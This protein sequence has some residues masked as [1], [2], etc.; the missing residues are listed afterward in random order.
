VND[1]AIKV[2]PEPTPAAT[3][4][5]VSAKLS[6]AALFESGASPAMIA[7][8]GG[9]LAAAAGYLASLGPHLSHRNT[10]LMWVT[11]AV[12]LVALGLYEAAG[13]AGVRAGRVLAAAVMLWI[14]WLLLASGHPIEFTI[15]WLLAGLAVPM[16]GYELLS[17]STGAAFLRSERLLLLASSVVV[18]ICW[19]YL[20]LAS[21]QPALLTPTAKCLPACPRNVL[22]A[23]SSPHALTTVAQ[24]VLRAGW[25]AAAFGVVAAIARRYRAAGVAERRAVAPMLVVAVAYAVVVTV[26]VT[27]ALAG[28]DARAPLVWCS[29][30]VAT[31]LP[32][33]MLAGR[34]RER[35]YMG[36]ALEE[37]VNRLR[38]TAPEDL[39][40]LMAQMLNDPSVQIGYSQ[41]AA[42]GYVDSSGDSVELPETDA[43]QAVTAVDSDRL[44][45]AVVIHRAA[46]PDEE[47]FIRAAGAAALISYENHRLEADLS[48]SF[49]ELAASRKRLAEAAYAERQRIERDLHD[50]IQQRIVGA[51]VR[52]ELADEALQSNPARGRR[53][54][55]EIGCDM[56]E[57][58]EE[59]R[60]LAQGVYPALLATHGLIEAL[61]SVARRSP[62][63]VTVQG[64]VARYPE[65]TEAAVYFC[66]LETLQNV[67]KHAGRGAT[68]TVRLW[69]EGDTLRFQTQ[70]SGVGFTPNGTQGRG[71]VNMRDR[72]AAV[73]GGLTLRSRVGVGT[74]VGGCVPVA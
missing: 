52:L 45:D 26:C 61:R 1:A 16:L 6:Q 22:F 32:L 17:S 13:G 54:L 24:E 19:G 40:A 69:Q 29:V 49:V 56:D 38:D 66:C 2:G 57:A 18:A 12:S 9:L 21:R 39:R 73:G 14:V 47:R 30:I 72:L 46:V 41:P 11:V 34:V 35:L 51:R 67:A 4:V 64:D 8:G 10:P 42:R 58:L 74:V 27:I 31:V 20:A 25:L 3:R 53:M 44:P 50:G 36:E 60:S 37:F 15:G 55:A 5:G 43:D 63:P 48:A 23:G 62:G 70:D 59:V 71:L 28:L 7:I 33:A 65:D 68:A